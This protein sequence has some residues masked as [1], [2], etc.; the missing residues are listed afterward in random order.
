MLE[1]SQYKDNA[2]ATLTYSDENLPE[3]GSLVPRH[4][5]LFMKRLRRKL[6]PQ[7]IRYFGV[8]EYGE[9]TERPH[10]HLALFGF[11]SCQ[12]GFTAFSREGRPCC[13]PCV[14]VQQEWPHGGISLGS[15]TPESAAYTAG[16]VTKKLTRRD[17]PRLNGRH[18]EF[19]RMS[20]RPGIGGDAMHEVADVLLQYAASDG[21]VPTALRHGKRILPLGRYLTR[22]LRTMTGRA[23]GAP[24]IT[25]ATLKEKMR[26]LHEAAAAATSAPG[27]ARFRDDALKTAILKENEGRIS[28]VEARSAIFKKRGSI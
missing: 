22:R 18:P 27:M 23:P 8:G 12:R 15:L 1:A 13:V 20:L 21:D 14:S 24:E 6:E 19:A 25:L 17:D 5:Q 10:Y 2:F 7:Q 28:Q 3:C 4:L 11:P 16:Y 9:H 26:P